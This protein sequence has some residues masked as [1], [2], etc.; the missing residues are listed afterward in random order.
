M[1]KYTPS[2]NQQDFYDFIVNSDKNAVIDAVAGSGKTTTLV[3]ST[4]LIP[5]DKTLL[6]TA[7]NKS[8]AK[9]LKERVSGDNITV[10][11]VHGLGYNILSLYFN[12]EIDNLKYNKLLYEIALNNK[13]AL[14][15]YNFTTTIKSYVKKIYDIF[16]NK[17]VEIK[18]YNKNVI[19]ISNFGRLFYI[20]LENKQKGIKELNKIARDYGLQNSDDESQIA[21]YLIKI[22]ASITSKIDFTDMIFLPVLLNLQTQKYDYVYVDECLPIR[23]QILT[24]YGSVRIKKLFYKFTNKKPLPLV[25]TYNEETKEYENKRILNIWSNGIKDIYYVLLNNKRK[26]K[27]TVNHNF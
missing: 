23:T 6:F 14:N 19:A 15:K 9:E 27:S 21:F 8:I 18:Q 3:E 24:Q 26:I 13:E 2:K 16:K 11:T 17:D 10:S 7:F 22:G 20:N 1:K 4:K 12:P 25:V 5:K